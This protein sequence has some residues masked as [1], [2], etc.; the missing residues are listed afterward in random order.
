MILGAAPPPLRWWGW[1][2]RET[3]VPRGLLTLLCEE[4]GLPGGVTSH[5]VGLDDVQLPASSLAEALHGRLSDIAGAANVRVDPAERVRHAAGRN[6]LDLLALRA[7]RLAAAPDAVVCPGS[8]GEV[9]GVLRAASE[10][11]CAVV[12]FGGGTSVVGGV[13]PERGP[14]PSVI[15][16]DLR[17]L[18]TVIDVD[19]VAR[20]ATLQAGMRGPQAEHALQAR[21]LTLGHFPQSFEYA[22]IGGYAATR[23]AGQASTG[24]GRFDELA[25]GLRLIAPAGEIAV[26]A[27]PASAA[28]PSLLQVVLGS[29]GA[30]GVITEVTVRVHATPRRRRYAGWSLPDFE[31]GTALLREL[32]QDRIAPDVARLSDADETRASLALAAGPAIDVA[33]RYLGFRGH[34]EPCLLVLGWE[35]DGAAI[36]TRERLAHPLLRRHGAIALGT[37]PG[38]AWLH[39]RFDGPYLRDALLDRGVLVETLETAAAWSR[40]AAVK[41]AVNGALQRSLRARGTPPL[42]G[43]HVSHVYSDG[44]SLYFTVLGR[45]DPGHEVAQWTEAKRAATDALLGCGGT[46]THHHGVGVDH[47]PWLE[48][49]DGA[50]GISALRAVK[51]RLDPDGIMNPGKLFC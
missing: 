33:R 25:R 28:G 21:G 8:P 14:L 18:D 41:A 46:L 39:G 35:G 36:G 42:V 27:V 22:T 24:Y 31:S 11:A 50:T 10:A 3:E 44:A 29:E 7:G 12:P 23:S 15:A 5:P 32:A 6:Y 2:D 47:A 38:R 34:R 4:A 30:L 19:V 17:R 40:L 1:G 51:A 20:T 48:R 37:A 16:L 49:E 13:A 43:C 26:A 45:Q 9:A